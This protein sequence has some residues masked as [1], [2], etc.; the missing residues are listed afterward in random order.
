MAWEVLTML[1]AKVPAV[2]SAILFMSSVSAQAME[3]VDRPGPAL[4]VRALHSEERSHPQIND[5][6]ILHPVSIEWMKLVDRPRPIS[7]LKRVWVVQMKFQNRPGRLSAEFSAVA[8]SFR[9]KFEYGPG[10]VSSWLKATETRIVLKASHHRGPIG[11]LFPPLAAEDIKF[12][13]RGFTS[14]LAKI[15]ISSEMEFGKGSTESC[16]GSMAPCGPLNFAE[17]GRLP[18]YTDERL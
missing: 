6:D 7:N 14:S 4:A 1:I 10:E 17:M 12:G 18:A 13:D 15:N 11:N 5:H 3:F 9:M 8:E 16:I 2:I